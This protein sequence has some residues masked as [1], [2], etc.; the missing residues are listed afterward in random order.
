MKD[1]GDWFSV[2][3]WPEEET[4]EPCRSSSGPEPPAT[5]PCSQSPCSFRVAEFC[6]PGESGSVRLE[7]GQHRVGREG[8]VSEGT[9]S[10]GLLFSR[11]LRCIIDAY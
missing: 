1:W 10:A 5:V 7:I 8:A 6:L 3:Q 9:A 2:I 4:A 11:R